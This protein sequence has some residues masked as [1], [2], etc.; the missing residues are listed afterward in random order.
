M[1]DLG[2]LTAEDV[3]VQLLHGPVGS[4]DELSCPRAVPMTAATDPTPASDGGAARYVGRFECD[5]PGRYGF[6]VR[7]V[8][9]HPDV[10][11]PVELGRIAWAI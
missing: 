9:A 2:S 10:G 5:H 1:V 7:I 11:N 8:P 3:E 4:N 6:T